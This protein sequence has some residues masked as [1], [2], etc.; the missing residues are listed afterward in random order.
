[1]PLKVNG[2]RLRNDLAQLS[3]IG[4]SAFGGINRTSF[5]GADLLARRWYAERCATAALDL[6][7]D[8]LGNMFAGPGIASDG[9]PAPVWSGS[10]ID[11]VPDGGAFDGAVGSVAALECVR[12]LNEA[13]V[14][15]ARPVQAVVFSDEE[16]NYGHLFGSGGIARGYSA[17]QLAEMS[18]RDGDRVLDALARCPFAPASPTCTRV[19]KGALHAFVELHIEQ[20]PRLEAAG[21][22][23]GTV[24]SI[25]GLGGGVMEFVG[26]ADHAGATPMRARRDALLGAAYFLTRL[27]EVA[28]SVSP[29][30]VITCGRIK[31][32]PGGANVVPR[33]ASVTLDFRDPDRGRIEALTRAIIAEGEVAAG[34]YDLNAEFRADPVVDPVPLDNVVQTA[35]SAAADRLGLSHVRMTSAAGHDS[36][37]MA[38]VAPTGMIFVPSEGGR[39]HCP[40]EET[41]WRDI[42]N[43]ANVL[44]ECLIALASS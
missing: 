44:L 31:V 22:Q 14:D 41:D 20:G 8:G 10:H 18:G 12:R 3:Q 43:G 1:M 35:I 28:E 39:S 34:Q 15:L 33:L 40:E 25:V 16:G 19:R 17:E 21:T 7:V 9:G 26:R 11:T 30:A 36:Q 42:E 23:I 4:R 24:T 37:N 2:E 5:S 27:P 29:D 32:E 6:K 13:G 38:T